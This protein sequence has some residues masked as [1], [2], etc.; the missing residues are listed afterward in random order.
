[1]PKD[2]N[3]SPRI[4]N[5]K[6]RHDY[7]IVESFEVGLALRGSEVKSIRQGRA[8][9]AGGFA[10]VEPQT[11]ELWLY[12]TDISAYDHASSAP[13]AALPESK[14]PRKLLAHR[15]QIER[16]YG[17]TTSG[18]TTLVPLTLYFNDRGIA[19]IELAV[20]E[21][22]SKGDK[23]AGMKKQEAGRAIRTAMT[24]KRIG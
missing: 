21:G 18:G 7:H 16:L 3:H 17:L 11:M 24:R 20:A 23:R 22:K 2:E 6:A 14:R 19:K 8:S 10:R 5:R 12:D 15:K 4:V 9:I 1:M 13:G